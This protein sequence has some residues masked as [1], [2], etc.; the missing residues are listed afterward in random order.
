MK[1]GTIA[2]P[3]RYD[4]AHNTAPLA[5]EARLAPPRAVRWFRWTATVDGAL[6]VP[7]SSGDARRAH[8][9]L[10]R[11]SSRVRPQRGTVGPWFLADIVHNRIASGPLETILLNGHLSLARLTLRITKKAKPPRSR[12]SVR[13]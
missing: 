7:A 8:D 12:V 10:R 9:A 4:S 2:S 11:S 3:W 6:R 5:P 13:A 1:M